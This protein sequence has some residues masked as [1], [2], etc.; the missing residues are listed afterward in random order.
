MPWTNP[1][2]PGITIAPT[3]GVDWGEDQ[4]RLE[5]DMEPTLKYGSK[6]QYR[7]SR[8]RLRSAT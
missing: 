6:Q 8:R 5:S 3:E 7:I 1:Y 4:A 2:M